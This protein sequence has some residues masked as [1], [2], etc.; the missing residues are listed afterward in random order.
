VLGWLEKD[1]KL[2]EQWTE[3]FDKLLKLPADSPEREALEAELERIANARKAAIPN[4]RDRQPAE[5]KQNAGDNAHD[6]AVAR[7]P[8][9]AGAAVAFS[10]D[11]ARILVS[12]GF[13]ARVWDAHTL[14][15]MTDPLDLG[16]GV[17]VA[18]FSPDGKQVLTA[19]GQRVVVW[20]VE[21]GKPAAELKLEHDVHAAAFSPDGKRIATGSADHAA[22][23]WDLATAAPVAEFAPVEHRWPVRFVGFTPDGK[24]LVTSDYW[25]QPRTNNDP[26]NVPRDLSLRRWDAAT[27]KSLGAGLKGK[28]FSLCGA[29]LSADGRRALT[30]E[31]NLSE[32][33]DVA[34]GQ[35]LGTVRHD[36]DNAEKVVLS[37]DGARVA[38][39]SWGKVAVFEVADGAAKPTGPAIDTD[40]RDFVKQVAF[41]PDGSRLVV[42]AESSTFG[43]E[44]EM[45]GVWD[46]ASGRKLVAI[47]NKGR[48]LTAAFS[49][50]G[51]RVVV[52]TGRGTGT[53]AVVYNVPA[54]APPPLADAPATVAGH[55]PAPDD[56]DWLPV[57]DDFEKSDLPK[58]IPLPTKTPF[59]DKP[60]SRTTYHRGYRLGFVMGLLEYFGGDDVEFAVERGGEPFKQGYTDG[61][62]DARRVATRR[63]KVESARRYDAYQPPAGHIVNESSPEHERRV[64]TAFNVFAT[65]FEK[66]FRARLP[67]DMRAEVV[68]ATRLYAYEYDDYSRDNTGRGVRVR[69]YKGKFDSKKPGNQEWIVVRHKDRAGPGIDTRA[70]EGKYGFQF[71][72]DAAT[73]HWMLE[74]SGRHI[75]PPTTFSHMQ[76]TD[77][78]GRT[79]SGGSSNREGSP[80][81]RMVLECIA[82]ANPPPAAGTTR[83]A[84][85]PAAD[86]TIDRNGPWLARIHGRASH[87]EFARDGRLMVFTGA[88]LLLRDDTTFEPAAGPFARS[89]ESLKAFALAPDAAHVLTGHGDG[90]AVW[91]DLASGKPLFEMKHGPGGQAPLEFGPFLKPGKQPTMVNRPDDVTSVDI[92]PDG[93]RLA[94]GAFDK[95]ARVWDAATGKPIAELP[96]DGH[97]VSVAF[98]PAGAG[99]G[100]TRLLTVS[101]GEEAWRGMAMSK[102]AVRVWDI[103]AGKE[104]WKYDGEESN[105]PWMSFSPD[106]TRVVGVLNAGE[107][108][109]AVSPGR[110]LFWLDADTG[111][112][113]QAME[114]E[115]ASRSYVNRATFCADGKHMLVESGSRV[116][117]VEAATGKSTSPPIRLGFV[118]GFAERQP[119]VSPD[120]RFVA[121]GRGKAKAVVVRAE[122]G[123]P[124]LQLTGRYVRDDEEVPAVAFSP[125]GK[126]LAVVFHRERHTT[127]YAFP[128]PAAQ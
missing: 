123:Q 117:V 19:G 69:G 51:S 37:R 113:A 64:L 108:R 84:T 59:G 14:K 42:A 32:V 77:D 82:A 87:V 72:Y 91:W 57:F 58:D 101:R 10:G 92:S 25:K 20:D 61:G 74:R 127:V 31:Y 5:P 110:K 119:V 73:G 128:P 49:Q 88:M 35:R 67:E 11:G 75:T 60:E 98:A 65:R 112:V 93:T 56:P 85:A 111:K 45:T 38:V 2:R 106:G 48:A 40:T 39:V 63:D 43:L 22:R 41:S 81:R 124:A 15:P 99:K 90:V 80:V 9:L 96:H 53:A 24:T 50:D 54:D 120:A 118:S 28:G 29:D 125:D 44:S 27:G 121:F 23:V 62:T 21:T 70:F 105:P 83:P 26:R 78:T 52:G 126:R 13:V 102:C 116:Q 100:G 66:E 94:T 3:V 76:Q 55:L 17:Q 71:D 7:L 107:T 30:M 12:G 86:G 8:G 16:T 79:F 95:T 97:V 109:D 122:D 4:R 6:K 46:V 47:P 103:D 34:T 1:E 36:G 33:W 68:G 89:G 18:A 115:L 114:L 104:L